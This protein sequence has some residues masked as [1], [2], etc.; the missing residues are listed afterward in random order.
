MGWHRKSGFHKICPETRN[1][2]HLHPR[3]LDIHLH[4]PHSHAGQRIELRARLS[5]NEEKILACVTFPFFSLEWN[6][7]LLV[8]CETRGD[9]KK[10]IEITGVC[11]LT[12]VSTKYTKLQERYFL[13]SVLSLRTKEFHFSFDAEHKWQCGRCSNLFTWFSCSARIAHLQLR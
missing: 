12:D 7:F 2:L 10:E 6:F 5:E 8:L 9:S 3:F 13:F 4:S 1:L 11:C